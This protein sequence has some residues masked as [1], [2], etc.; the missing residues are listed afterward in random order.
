MNSQMR[1]PSEAGS[2]PSRQA[3][4]LGIVS[5]V[6]VVSIVSSLSGCHTPD[7]KERLDSATNTTDRLQRE[8]T[9]F[10][11]TNA[12]PISL[13][14]A[15][16]LAHARTLKLT[17][18]RLDRDLANIQKGTAFATF[19]PQVDLTFMRQGAD[20]SLHSSAIPVSI[21][22]TSFTTPGMKLGRY[23]TESQLTLT[24]P[25]FTPNAWLLFVEARNLEKANDYKL[26][27][28]REL[29]DVQVTALFYSTAVSAELVKAYTVQTN[30]S[31]TLD[32]QVANLNNQ[33]Y[34]LD[35]DRERIR[36]KLD[37]DRF[38]LV[39]AADRA[40][41][42]RARLADILR[43]WPGDTGLRVDG[44][45][46]TN[47]LVRPWAFVDAQGNPTNVAAVV[48]RTNSLQELLF[49]ALVNRKDLWAGDQVIQV[50]KTEIWRALTEWLPELAFTG[51][52]NYTKAKMLAETQYW[53]GGLM[54]AMS[55]FKGFQ[56]VNDYRKARV[57][58]AAEFEIQEDRMLAIAVSV[59][60]AHQN[61]DEAFIA[62]RV[63][64]QALK[65]AQMDYDA[66][67]KRYD[68]D[69]ETLS[70][71]LDKLTA[72]EEARVNDATATYASALA[73]IVLRD[74]VGAGIGKATP[75]SSRL[76]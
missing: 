21:L 28:A 44:A 62:R 45:S 22:G 8:T 65:A 57:E 51:S 1:F 52:G 14:Q 3:V 59:I 35:P 46:M 17:Q 55:V 40:N 73:E 69:Q 50:R 4:L 39:R 2:K 20:K 43:F 12:A 54:G 49:Q 27:R 32:T 70:K 42:A 41:L 25:L 10:L 37:N 16:A 48:A 47:V 23:V 75:I 66:T 26:A 61:W 36:A 63:A 38:E 34:A 60:E 67:K 5:I 29:L 72:L 31:E 30:S 15:L 74:A 76:R 64:A 19:L 9:A 71:V 58:K 53:S 11:A 18:T 56:S 13:E 7:I 68:Q 33:G 6:S 24:Q